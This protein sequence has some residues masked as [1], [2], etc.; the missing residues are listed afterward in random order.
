MEVKDIIQLVIDSRP[1]PSQVTL[2]QAA[3]M[4]NVSEPTARK[5]VRTGVIKLNAAGMISVT[6][7]DRVLLSKAA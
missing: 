4:L 1:R 2:K 3:E 5:F 6:E 7:I